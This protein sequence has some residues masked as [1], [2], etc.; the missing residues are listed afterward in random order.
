MTLLLRGETSQ[1]DLTQV[2]VTGRVTPL[3]NGEVLPIQVL[4]PT[5]MVVPSPRRFPLQL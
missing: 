5:D 2:L 3:L 4:I 1:G